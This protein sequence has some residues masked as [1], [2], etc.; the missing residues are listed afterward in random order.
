ML[1]FT[2]L[3]AAPGL[4]PRLGRL[5]YPGRKTLLTPLYLGNTSRGAVPHISQDNYQKHT[6]L[7]GVYVPLEDF[8]E[9]YLEKTPPVFQIESQTSKLRRFVSLPQDSLLVLGARRQPPLP[10]PAANTN[11]QISIST[12]VG[13]R[14]LSSEY[15][16]AAANVLRPDIVVGLADIP[17]GKESVSSK[18][19][20]K[21][22]DRTTAWMKDLVLKRSQLE[23]SDAPSYN[24]FAPILPIDK[25]LQSWYLDHLVENM[26]DQIGGVAIY[27]SQLLEDLPAELRKLPRLSFDN[28]ASPQDLLRQIRLGIDL[29][30]VPFLAAATD[31]GIALDFTFPAPST[32]E[33]RQQTPRQSLGIDMWGTEHAISVTPLTPTCKCYACTKHHRAYIQHLLSAKEM[34]GWVLI[35]LH[36]HAIM[37]AF[38]AGV[39]HSIETGTFEDDVAA[40]EAFYEPR[41]PE[42]TGQGPRVR[43]YQYTSGE[44]AKPNKKNPK[45]FRSLKPL[46]AFHGQ[47]PNAKPIVK[48]NIDDDALA[49]LA[50]LENR[51][52]EDE[53]ESPQLKD[54]KS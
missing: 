36:N 26:A 20:D 54:D 21:M 33:S 14:A 30:T 15:Y 47:Q 38:F 39:R 45:A 7:N 8:I 24:I 35:Q 12:S 48:D 43:G 18:R 52:P 31:A 28:P 23:K 6:R 40:F 25:E 32:S 11:S 37:D 41:L 50:D 34:L 17:Y 44:N 51:S 29:F 49:G 2:L 19:K 46:N 22:S 13:Y 9:R 42:K 4:A 53:L 3:N 27:D 16:A 5:S 10:C 1:H